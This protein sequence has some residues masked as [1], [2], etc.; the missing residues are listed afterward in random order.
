MKFLWGENPLFTLKGGGWEKINKGGGFPPK[1]RKP[2]KNKKSPGKR[3][4]PKNP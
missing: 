2:L 4:T 3:Q 1:L